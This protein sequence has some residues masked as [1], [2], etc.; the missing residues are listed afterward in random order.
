MSKTTFQKI[1]KKAPFD[2]VGLFTYLRT[3]ARRHDS[4]DPNST[5]ESWEEC[6]N[7]VCKASNEQLKVG[8]SDD[9]LQELFNL[10]FNLKC[11]VAGRFLW[12]LGT[13]TVENC[14][15]TSLQN[16]AFVTVNKPIEP[17]VWAMNF[18]MLGAGVGFR[19]LPTD[20]SNFPIVKKVQITREDKTF[21]SI[22][23]NVRN[24]KF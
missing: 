4:S 9:E 20:I 8:F 2:T 12:Q 17:F 3:Y 1:R 19:V 18:L 11:S 22:K 23:T 13:E 10:L 14:G 6:I 24:T 5:V 7:R 15:L 21:E 16:C